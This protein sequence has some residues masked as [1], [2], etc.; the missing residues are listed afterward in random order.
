M[1]GAVD[2]IEAPH[3]KSEKGST[4]VCGLEPQVFVPN[5]GQPGLALFA[6]LIICQRV[7]V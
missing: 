3:L 7:V 2:D 4:R 5:V 1:K 6:H